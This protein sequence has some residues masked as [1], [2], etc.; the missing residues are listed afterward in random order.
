M[1]VGPQVL[2]EQLLTMLAKNATAVMTNVPGPQQ[3]LYFAGGR[4]D[5]LMFWVPQSGNIGMG[6][7]IMS[8]AGDVQFGLIVDRS[9][10]P[11]PERVIERFAPEF[12]KLVLATLMA[13]WPWQQAPGAEAIER[14]ALA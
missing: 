11:D 13:P 1:G 2:Q 12:E 8:Y 6:V 3:T 14:L 4:I 10:C 9:L 5:R 7:S